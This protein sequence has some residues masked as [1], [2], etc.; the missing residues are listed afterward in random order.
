[1]TK[2]FEPDAREA[3]NYMDTAIL[4]FAGLPLSAKGGAYNGHLN[5]QRHNASVLLPKIERLEKALDLAVG[6]LGKSVEYH[7]FGNFAGAGSCLMCN[8]GESGGV[9]DENGHDMGCIYGCHK[10]ILAEIERIRK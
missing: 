4:V 9:K 3:Q 5:G 1:M 8:M 7:F 10:R 2:Q 6:A